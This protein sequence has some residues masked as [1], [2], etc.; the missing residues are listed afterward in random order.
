MGWTLTS[1][2][3]PAYPSS[4]PRTPPP[5][6]IARSPPTACVPAARPRLRAA[7][8][9]RAVASSRLPFTVQKTKLRPRMSL[10]KFQI[11]A[12]HRFASSP[13][14][15]RLPGGCGRAR[16]AGRRAAQRMS[17]AAAPASCTF[18]SALL[19]SPPSSWRGPTRPPMGVPSVCIDEWVGGVNVCV[20]VCM[21]SVRGCVTVT[22]S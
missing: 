1:C 19:W 20:R 3:L 22:I 13:S 5:R 11:C 8:A 10:L 16:P 15:Q 17:G 14:W 7:M 2:P 21:R 4:P 18:P 6:R 12:L 9:T